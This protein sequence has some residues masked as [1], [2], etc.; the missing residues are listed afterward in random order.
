MVWWLIIVWIAGGGTAIGVVAGTA[1]GVL[2]PDRICR[3]DQPGT[4]CRCAKM[5]HE[6]H[7]R[8]AAGVAVGWAGLAITL[9]LVT[10][11]T[12]CLTVPA[13]GTIAVALTGTTTL[14]GALT[15]DV[16][17]TI[18]CRWEPTGPTM[19]D[20]VAPAATPLADE[21]EA[22]LAHR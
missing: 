19:I 11:E 20:D 7:P 5:W 14:V 9:A 1:A 12:A 21:V 10:V 18:R 3:H 2:G 22:W 16:V 6:R 4:G 8:V 17:R 13:T 15:W